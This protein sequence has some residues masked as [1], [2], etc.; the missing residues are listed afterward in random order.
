MLEPGVA[1]TN[2]EPEDIDRDWDG[3][4]ACFIAEWCVHVSVRGRGGPIGGEEIEICSGV[5][6]LW[7][8]L[9]T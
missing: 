1:P 3:R 9:I 2:G 4:T 8:G 7:G 6:V 5:S